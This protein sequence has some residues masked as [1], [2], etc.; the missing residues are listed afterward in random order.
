[1]EE[2]KNRKAIPETIIKDNGEKYFFQSVFAAAKF[3]NVS[4]AT[5]FLTLKRGKNKFTRRSD[6]TS[7]EVFKTPDEKP[8]SFLGFCQKISFPDS[9][10]KN[11][12]YDFYKIKIT[13]DPQMKIKKSINFLNSKLESHFSQIRN[14]MDDEPLKCDPPGF[15]NALKKNVNSNSSSSFRFTKKQ[16]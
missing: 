16:N 14:I 4:T 9:W 7:F 8:N 1:M 12:K 6:K 3:C 15:S 5:I 13:T 10:E 11:D 2:K